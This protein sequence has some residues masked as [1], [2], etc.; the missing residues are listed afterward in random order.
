MHSGYAMGVVFGNAAAAKQLTAINQWLR[1][2][3][4]GKTVPPPC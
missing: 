4:M 1:D 3:A 2:L